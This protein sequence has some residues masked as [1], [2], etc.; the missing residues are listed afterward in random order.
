M[1][2]AT[3]SLDQ[4]AFNS[5]GLFLIDNLKQQD[6]DLY[7]NDRFRFRFSDRSPLA[8]TLYA[9]GGLPLYLESHCQPGA[10]VIELRNALT[11]ETLRRCR[12]RAIQPGTSPAATDAGLF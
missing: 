3:R 6:V 7:I 1:I 9:H 10:N 12:M 5:L 11:G 4:A 8:R 2:A